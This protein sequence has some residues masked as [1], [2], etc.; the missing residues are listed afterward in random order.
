MYK[1]KVIINTF[2]QELLHSCLGTIMIKSEHWGNPEWIFDQGFFRDR[3]KHNDAINVLT[4]QRLILVFSHLFS[5]EPKQGRYHETRAVDSANALIELIYSYFQ[6]D[7]H[8]W[9]NK[10]AINNNTERSHLLECLDSIL[11]LCEGKDVLPSAEISNCLASYLASTKE[12]ENIKIDYPVFL[13]DLPYPRTSHFYGRTEIISNIIDIILSKGSCYLY[14]IGGIG[15]TE[16][17]KSVMNHFLYTPSSKSGITHIMWVDYTNKGFKD[18]LIRVL[19]MDKQSDDPDV[20]FHKA[21][22]VINQYQDRLLLIVDNVEDDRDND[23]LGIC[24]Y[25]RCHVLISSRIDGFLGISKVPIEEL[26][27][28]DCMNLFYSY[29]SFKHDDDSLQKIISLAD[30]HTVTVE[31]LAKIADTEE[32][33]L[34]TFLSELIKCG[35]N[36]SDEKASASH[37]RMRDE[38]RIIVQLQKLFQIHR[39]TENEQHFLIQF[40]TIPSL[41]FTFSQAKKWFSIP[42]RTTLNNLTRLGW[43]KMNHNCSDTLK[44]RN[45]SMHSVIAAT[46]RSHFNEALYA[47]CH[48]FLLVLSEEMFFTKTEN[49]AERKEL[50]PYSQSLADILHDRFCSEDD[51]EFLM[52]LGRI[53]RDINNYNQAITLFCQCLSI[54]KQIPIP[55]N[56]ILGDIYNLLGLTYAEM[57]L[58]DD[59]HNSFEQCLKYMNKTYNNNSIIIATVYMNIANLYAQK[60]ENETALEYL[61]KARH[62]ISQHPNDLEAQM[63]LS[64]LYG[65]ISFRQKEYGTA[66]IMF[67]NALDILEQL[68]DEWKLREA[69]IIIHLGEIE[70]ENQHPDTAY[71]LFSAAYDICLEHLG[72]EHYYTLHIL[73]HCAIA[74]DAMGKSDESLSASIEVKEAYIEMYGEDHSKMAPI[75]NN[76]ALALLHLADIDGAI[77]NFELAKNIFELHYGKYN[78]GG[79]YIYENLGEA[80]TKAKNYEK[81][82][83]YIKHTLSIVNHHYPDKLS[84][85]FHGQIALAHA[86]KEM[87]NYEKARKH[88]K[89]ALKGISEICGKESALYIN[90][91]YELNESVI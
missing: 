25:L 60:E 21:V 78:P 11:A 40:S 90:T 61:H 6:I 1:D 83:K 59:S 82:I 62:I 66:Q 26:S 47:T 22:T 50:V 76:I 8:I 48:D 64:I 12:Q 5:P 65:R 88:Y 51:V 57:D 45:Y 84:Y 18:A 44:Q 29:Y 19:H 54:L 42:N 87:G 27:M 20:A 23:L 33:S 70:Y 38:N 91:E 46:V 58:F 55:Q 39:F 77:Q 14:G 63:H 10:H 81:A 67:L 30:R 52:S 24:G 2:L 17:A 35:F 16:V 28:N 4:H 34:A 9:K 74:L 15:K 37:E 7:L 73:N 85:G 36:I 41:P 3:L 13:T 75:Y 43:L 31:L 86:Y 68:P 69:N 32:V 89:T 56:S 71:E 49:G 72:K 80:Y 53:Y 79:C